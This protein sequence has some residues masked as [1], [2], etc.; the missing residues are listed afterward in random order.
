M[1]ENVKDE[2]EGVVVLSLFDGMSCGQIALEQAGVK[3]KKYMASEIKKVAIKQTLK[4]FP[5][6]IMVGDVTKL[7]YQKTTKRLYAN[8]ERKVVYTL[9]GEGKKE[10]TKEELK[11][12]RR[13][14]LQVLPNGDVVKWSKKGRV[15]VHEGEIDLLIG[16]SPCQGFSMAYGYAK[17]PQTS[18]LKH[19][20]SVLFFDYLRLLK[21]IRPKK[22]FLENVKMSKKN[23]KILSDYLGRK[24]IHINSSL[25]T[26]Q[27]RERVYWTNIK[28]VKPPKDLKISF[29]DYK[30]KTIPRVERRIRATKFEGE[31]KPL[32]LTPKEI[33]EIYE[34]NKWVHDELKAINPKATK[35]D[36]VEE[37]HQNLF[38]T[39]A[40]STPS[41]DRYWN[42]G[43][44]N[45]KKYRYMCK[46]VT[47]SEKIDTISRKQDRGPN[48]GLVSL[49]SYFRFLS[50]IELCKGQ[51]VSY[52][53]L[54][55][56]LYSQI[57]DLCGDGWSI[58]IIAHFFTKL[59]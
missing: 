19:V 42:N 43:I 11:S 45:R 57:Q 46:N 28:G 3:V 27:N 32:N 8:C 14:K 48:S 30:L 39:C 44:Y 25:L 7:H 41:K 33:D 4:N 51:G 50:P 36:V 1:I 23:E 12:F 37:V 56:L 15:L 21:E 40:K 31:T 52:H 17:S 59:K 18:G 54:H 34:M 38:I 26:F 10:W 6:T 16:G 20:Q 22:W 35:E 24:G 2:N 29:Q 13:R 47:F 9:E 53:Y 49:D 5:N 55:N 58:P